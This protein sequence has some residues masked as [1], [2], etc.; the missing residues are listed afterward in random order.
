M[1]EKQFEKKILFEEGMSP[2]KKKALIEYAR[3]LG[4]THMASEFPV[5]DRKSG[6]KVP[7]NLSE[8]RMSFNNERKISAPSGYKASS[9]KSFPLHDFDSRKRKGLEKMFSRGNFLSDRDNDGLCDDMDFHIEIPEDADNSLYEACA[10]LAFR[11]GMEVT[12]FSGHLTEKRGSNSIVFEES[13]KCSMKLEDDGKTIRIQGKGKKLTD[14]ISLVCERFPKTESFE[15]LSEKMIELRDGFALGSL[16]GQLSFLEKYRDRKTEAYFS[17]EI[18]E[19]LDE[20]KKRYPDT[21]FYSIKDDRKIFEEE[22]DLSW[23]ADDLREILNEDVYPALSSG[24]T[25]EIE[26]AISED[27]KVRSEIRNEIMDHLK[28]KGIRDVRVSVL[29]SYKNGFSWID[30]DIIPKIQSSGK[31]MKNGKV[32]IRFRPFLRDGES[33]W[34]S[35]SGVIPSYLTNK[36]DPEK[37]FDLPIRYLQEL[38]PIEDV[39][40]EKLGINPENV[41]FSVYEGNKDITY[42]VSAFDKEGKEI[43]KEELKAECSERPY[44][45]DF[46]ELGLVHPSTGYIRVRRIT[47]EKESQ[48][49]DEIFKKRIITD[50]EK[51]WTVYQEKILPKVR[52]FIEDKT[53]GE[54]LIS[55]QPFFS[56]LVIEAE[57]S[58]PDEKLSSREDLFSSLDGIHEDIYFA[59][60]DY[61]K[62]YGMKRNGELTD[63]PGLILPVI[64]K[65]EGKPYLK[66]TLYDRL[67]SKPSVEENGKILETVK[68]KDD[69]DVYICELESDEGLKCVIRVSGADEDA[70]RN[71]SNLSREG[72][73]PLFNDI[74]YFK[75]IL[76]ETEKERYHAYSGKINSEK[77]NSEDDIGISSN[78]DIRDIDISE[79]RL[80]G[81]EDYLRIIEELKKVSGIKVS[82]V[83]RSYTGRKVY[84]VEFE[85]HLKGYVSMTKRITGVPSQIIDSR[86]HANEV[87]STNSAFMLIRKI[88][89][90][91]DFYEL[92]DRINLAILPMENV[93]GSHIHYE[94]AKDNPEW[95]LHVA[96]FNA[97]GKEFY[98]DLF[99]E[100]T[101]HTEALAMRKLF[102]KYLPDVIIDN[103]GVPSHEW[104]QQFSGY[105]SPSYKGFWLPRSL[106]Y[107]YFFHITGEDYEE[108]INLNREFEKIIADAFEKDEEIRNENISWAR[109]FEKYAHRWMPEMFPADYYKNMINYWIPH[110]YDDSHRYPSIKFPWIVSMDYVS[111]VADETAQGAYLEKCA[112]AH[113]VH[114]VAILRAMMN[115]G[116]IYD[117]KCDITEDGI[118]LK[119]KRKRPIIIRT[120][121]D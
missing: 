116:C 72:V 4:F 99:K 52:E 24:D 119:N 48:R 117:E 112:R 28:D 75:E 108:N 103:H 71:F 39:I 80:I 92:P 57:L 33:L 15:D 50:T 95:K 31:S 38:Y 66:V 55:M 118:S 74:G 109:Q 88:L 58:E 8:I 85:P 10:D 79:D 68:N 54:N 76:L 32:L 9:D 34:T 65:K 18:S 62:N 13:E 19:R 2:D 53:H 87:S 104:E 97:I 77:M 113:V 63:A 7:E 51:V 22:Y 121:E 5:T 115:A 111:E 46:E 11:Y 93:D 78:V 69:I 114:D 59:G 6:L 27:K 67:K 43:L 100:G 45:T 26:I 36:A 82:L 70:V 89:T 86:H 35:E 47:G 73:I 83:A 106:L 49:K 94:L 56:R 105:T 84:A 102:Y 21:E 30:E 20:L 44:L 90:D 41:E 40:A 101:I 16:N 37:W 42:E 96:R 120:G 60:S 25:Y 98:H 61:F 3:I 23:E 1:T 91:K 12:E 64:R 17:E 29:S 110:E 107:G 81:Y 14:F